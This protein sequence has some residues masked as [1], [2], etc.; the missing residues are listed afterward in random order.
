MQD[1]KNILIK[2]S[3]SI[4][5]SPTMQQKNKQHIIDNYNYRRTTRIIL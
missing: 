2:K 5:W 4:G 1:N 3:D